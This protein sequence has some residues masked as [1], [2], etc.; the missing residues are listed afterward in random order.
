MLIAYM[1][2]LIRVT[3]KLRMGVVAATGAICLVYISA[4]V[5]RMFGVDIPF[6]SHGTPLGIAFS[7]VVVGIAAFNLL[8][9]FDSI[10]QMSRSYAPKYMEWYGAFGLMITLIW[11]YLEILTLLRKLNDRR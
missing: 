9:D 3:D 1:S 4:I 11:L 2:G 5:L 8:L 6:L 7:V 10:E